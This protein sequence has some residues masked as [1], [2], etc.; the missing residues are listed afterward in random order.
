MKASELRGK[1]ATELKDMLLELRKEQFGLRMQ[2]GNGTLE[3]RHQLKA[4]RRNI[5]RVKTAMNQ[6]QGESA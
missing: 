4:V 5:A 3:D 1:N 6:I 2:H